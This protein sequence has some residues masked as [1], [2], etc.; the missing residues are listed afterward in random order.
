M[1]YVA[2]PKQAKRNFRTPSS[3]CLGEATLRCVWLKQYHRIGTNSKEKHKQMISA[4]ALTFKLFRSKKRYRILLVFLTILAFHLAPSYSL[5][6]FHSQ[7]SHLETKT[8]ANNKDVSSEVGS[9]NISSTDPTT[10]LFYNQQNANKSVDIPK[11]RIEIKEAA[12]VNFKP[13]HQREVI[14]NVLEHLK[15]EKGVEV[16][17]QRGIF[18]AKIL[19]RWSYCQKYILVDLWGIQENYQDSSNVNDSGQEK[20]MNEAITRVQPWK[21]KI[22]VC[23]NFSI[24]CSEEHDD[25]S[26]DF[27]Y[28]DA[29][30]DFKAVLEDLEAW[31]PKVRYGGIIAGHDHTDSLEVQLRIGNDWNIQDDGSIDYS[32][33][34]ARGA[35]NLFF[36]L[37]DQFMTWPNSHTT[38]FKSWVVLK[39]ENSR[40]N[41]I[42][43]FVDLSCIEDEN[44]KGRLLGVAKAKRV[45]EWTDI[46]YGV[47]S[48][49]WTCDLI[50]KVFPGLLP[51]Y[52][53]NKANR[54]PL[55]ED[56]VKFHVLERFGG[57]A[58]DFRLQPLSGVYKFAE[59]GMLMGKPFGFCTRARGTGAS[60]P[61]TLP[62]KRCPRISTLLFGSA[63]GAPELERMAE[64]HLNVSASGAYEDG[65][66][67]GVILYQILQK[68]QMD[69]FLL[70]S[71]F[72]T[73]ACDSLPYTAECLATELKD[74]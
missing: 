55:L 2:S 46:N 56:F 74:V 17:V 61:D 25:L 10:L 72:P 18:A 59:K 3:A 54:K 27:A 34:A 23:R 51:R 65:V 53:T 36:A 11:F 8:E 63:R 69:V 62:A 66:K 1:K 21:E 42:L 41:L 57:I 35:V 28:V 52:D 4:K 73:D 44:G 5:S 29:R 43:H 16:G 31:Y 30:H 15:L 48:I 14:G 6:P 50:S 19:K 67:P 12:Y 45:T 33:Q 26:L 38:V 20:L 70:N 58:V 39:S 49:V 37:K 47:T 71:P 7:S 60:T 13:T 64:M 22:Q 32:R 40:S 24:T 9:E 68:S